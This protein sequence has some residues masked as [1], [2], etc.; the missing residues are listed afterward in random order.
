MI[1]TLKDFNEG[2]GWTAPVI[3]TKRERLLCPWFFP[4]QS[5][6]LLEPL[7][8]LRPPTL[9]PMLRQRQEGLCALPVHFWEWE[10]TSWARP[11]RRQDILRLSLVQDTR[12]SA[13]ETPTWPC[14]IIR[15]EAKFVNVGMSGRKCKSIL[16][17]SDNLRF[18]VPCQENI[19]TSCVVHLGNKH[20]RRVVFL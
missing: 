15:R 9:S 3:S 7:M 1:S 20:E 5:V 11:K 17:S 13:M 6:S 19:V 18:H 4:P 14:I 2:V 12:P 10:S 16:G 8:I